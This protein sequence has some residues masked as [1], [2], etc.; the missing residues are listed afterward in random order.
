MRRTHYAQSTRHS[1]CST[2]LELCVCMCVG[3]SVYTCV[4]IWSFQTYCA[5]SFLTYTPL[6]D[7]LPAAIA[8]I[9][10]CIVIVSRYIPN[11]PGLPSGCRTQQ[12]VLA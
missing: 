7:P 10:N 3:V 11:S 8:L 6:I 9:Y 2:E 1:Y 12:T 4:V 5:I